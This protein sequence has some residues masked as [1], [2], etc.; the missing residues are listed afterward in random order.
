MIISDNADLD[1]FF[2]QE[3]DVTVAKNIEFSI[4]ITCF[5][6]MEKYTLYIL[7]VAEAEHLLYEKA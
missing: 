5:L 6:F 2:S 1:G 3:S 7:L 4:N